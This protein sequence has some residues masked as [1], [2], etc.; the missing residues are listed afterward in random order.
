MSPSRV[1]RVVCAILML[2]MLLAVLF[3]Q[4]PAPM[5]KRHRVDPKTGFC[6]ACDELIA[7]AES[8]RPRHTGEGGRA[9]TRVPSWGG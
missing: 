8:K 9:E 7:R 1:D 3:M 4:P 2:G 5:S 6:P